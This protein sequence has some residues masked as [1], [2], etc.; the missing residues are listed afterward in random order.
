MNN[1]TTEYLVK[2]LAP[3]TAYTFFVV[4]YSPMGASRPSVPVTIEMMEDVPSAPPQLA[5]ASSSPTEIRLMWHPL[6]S[7][8]SRGTVTHYRIEYSTMEQADSVFSVEVGGNETQFTLSEL[9]PN[10]LYRVRIAAGTGI[11]FGVPSDWVQHR[12]LARYD[13]SDHSILIFAPTE[14]KVRA[15]MNTLNVTWQPSPNHTLASGYKLSYREVDAAESAKTHTVR[16]R[17]KARYHLLTGMVPNRQYEVKVWAFSKQVDGAVAVWKGRT[18]KA[19][20]R[21]SPLPMPP[22]LPPGSIQAMANSSTSIWL[23]W[24]K[25][26]FSNV[27]IINYTVRCS[28]AGTTNASLVSYHT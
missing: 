16:L 9:E 5:I 21:P 23:R 3:H 22:P 11:G 25:P 7:E 6:P 4:A 26:R 8:R 17:K 28:P 13:H 12:T 10:Q 27:R 19:H 14:L 1:D 18:E 15:H 20:V 24:E 2:E